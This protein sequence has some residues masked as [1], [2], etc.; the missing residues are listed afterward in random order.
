MVMG[1]DNAVLKDGPFLNLPLQLMYDYL[2]KNYPSDPTTGPMRYIIPCDRLAPL[3]CAMAEWSFD[4]ADLPKVMDVCKTYFN[5]N[6]WPN[7]P[8]EIECTRTDTYLMSAWNWPG[9]P[10]IV[11]L[12]FQY[13]TA[14]LDDSG[15]AE[16]VVH[17]KGVW[18]ALNAAGLRFKAHWGKINFNTPPVVAKNYGLAAFLPHVKPMFMNDYLRQRFGR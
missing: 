9:L 1:L 5:A 18:D 3:P 10:Y 14:F 16:V 12:N 2:T 7:L 17:L 4:P 11:K 15:K 13:L 8:V 6:K